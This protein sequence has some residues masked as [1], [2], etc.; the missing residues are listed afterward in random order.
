MEERIFTWSLDGFGS[1]LY[2]I[3]VNGE[4]RFVNIYSSMEQ[5]EIPQE[6]KPDAGIE[7]SSFEEFWS[8]FIDQPC[9]LRYRPMFIHKDYK[10][11]LRLYFADLSEESLSI[12]DQFRLI[13]WQHKLD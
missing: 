11:F 3:A 1:T 2:R 8:E 4:V 12:E 7:Y 9:W 10:L 5:D 13:I 6:I